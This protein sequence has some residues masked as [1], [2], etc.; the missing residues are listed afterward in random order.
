MIHFLINLSKSNAS[1]ALVL[2]S[3]PLNLAKASTALRLL[4]NGNFFISDL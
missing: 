2:I 3:D 1:A 4:G